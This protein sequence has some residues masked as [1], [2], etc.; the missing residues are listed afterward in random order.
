MNL[1]DAMSG[2][3]GLAGIRWLLLGSEPRDLVRRKLNLLLPTPELLGACHLRHA[4][5]RI[6]PD[7]K[8]SAYYSMDLSDN[9]FGVHNRA[10]AAM[11]KPKWIA[12][13]V[14]ADRV[15]PEVAEMEAQAVRL[16]VAAPFR[17]LTARAS[18]WG[19][20]IQVSPLDTSFPQLVRIHDPVHIRH[21]LARVGPSNGQRSADAVDGCYAV[22]SI[23]YQPGQR[24]LLRYD[25]TA[26]AGR[27]IFAK[28]Y[29]GGE[30]DRN[31][32]IAVR[33]A[34]WISANLQGATCL[35]PLAYVREDDLV[36]YPL[37][38]GTP[39]HQSLLGQ[40]HES[41]RHL[42]L[43][44]RALGVLHHAPRTLAGLCRPRS[45]E[46]EIKEVENKCDFVPMLLPSAGSAIKDL[47]A[48]AQALYAHLPQEAP[49]FTHGDFKAEHL[50]ATPRGLTV[51]D[52][53]ISY[54]G[55]P[56]ADV[57]RFLADLTL[58]FG[59]WGLPG[60][61][62]A[63][64]RFLAGYVTAAPRE[65]LIRARLFEALDLI[66]S[67]GRRLSFFDVNWE[68]RVASLLHRAA[69]VLDTLDGESR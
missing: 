52:L 3:T 59:A 6:K 48:R 23:K 7:V 19:L 55:D 18:S 31:F 30:G 16:G 47:I 17:R 15:T 49:T 26:P 5:L 8:L 68:D 36:L 10:I 1:T 27:T 66:R 9:G 21:I 60:V 24:H 40:K 25:S 65:R 69:A 39:L 51:I 44:G 50:W 64:E 2:R 32:Q 42:E 57:G 43:A 4:K 11:W 58:W 20:H 63:R 45:F 53:D 54:L 67:T 38:S 37:L 35:R 56:A 12:R 34:D 13:G 33:A 41:G 14:A 29:T 62:E 46:A 22:T 28:A 61:A